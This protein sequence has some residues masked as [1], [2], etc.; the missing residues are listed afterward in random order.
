VLIA[1][2]VVLLAPT[3][4]DA[5]FPGANGKIAFVRSG[6]IWTMNPDGTSQ[7]NLTND[8]IQQSSP[9]WSADGNRI[10]YDQLVSDKHQVWHMLA[11]GSNKVQAAPAPSGSGSTIDRRRDPAWSPDGSRIVFNH[12]AAI[13][14]MDTD[15]TDVFAVSH[16]LNDPEW[17]PAGTKIILST[18][19]G[20]SGSCFSNWS[21]LAIVNPDSTGYQLLTPGQ[22]CQDRRIN[23][24]SWS[25]DAQRIAY[26]Q[27]D[28]FFPGSAEDGL[29]TIKPDGTDRQKVSLLGQT[30][31]WSP[32]GTKFAFTEG[33]V[34]EN[35]PTSIRVM[36]SDGTD[37]SGLIA[38][39][40][41]PDWQ[42]LPAG[43]T[44]ADVLATIT[45]SP[46]PVKG[47]AELHYTA[48]AA[49]FVGPNDASGVTL[50][51]NLPA[52]V[53]YVSATPTQGSCSHSAGVVTC[54]LGSLTEGAT[55]SVDILTEARNVNGP[56]TI[57]ASATVTATETDPVPGNNTAST[58]TQVTFGAYARPKSAT[59][60]LVP[61]VPSYKVC[62]PGEDTLE[63][64]P[65]LGF[66]S[67]SNPQQT[68]GHLTVGTPDANS[69][70]ANFVG[71]VRYTALNEPLPINTANGDQS[72]IGLNVSMTGVR[73]KT[74]LSLYSGGVQVDSTLQITDHDSGAG[75]FTSNTGQPPNLS[76]GVPCSAG[77][78]T[79]ASTY[80]AVVP[81]AVKELQR[82]IWEFGAVRVIDGGADGNP[83][84]SPNTVFATQGVFVP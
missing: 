19:P 51:I 29:F 27:D 76:F 36:D 37:V 77:N 81:G 25:P 13:F 49:N 8:A 40:S 73:N 45:D 22:A 10:A 66:P 3:T 57:N 42:P 55:A 71:S 17:S 33:T 54:N 1:L 35:A 63:H 28:I 43:P 16:G 4:A 68:S 14:T 15:G 46:D 11:D 80:E 20:G 82:A 6:D 74:D 65:P 83:A 50:T 44:S 70:A 75:G 30:P 59:P 67:C 61:L 24:S 38:S 60:L 56:A 34:D 23:Y 84:T 62:G 7:M 72:D 21:E 31:A 12:A 41:H 2:A 47:G 53:F 26:F 5:S 69:L 64:A 32:D 52:G 48:T 39:G 58:S 9:A 78:C 79:L 18:L